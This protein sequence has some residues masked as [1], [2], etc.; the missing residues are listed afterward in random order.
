[1]QKKDAELIKELQMENNN[2]KEVRGQNEKLSADVAKYKKRSQDE[3]K[4]REEGEKRIKELEFA[5]EEQKN[6]AEEQGKRL[7]DLIAEKF[8]QQ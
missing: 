7:K 3:T 6:I 8:A 2:L 4:K 5:L 1:M